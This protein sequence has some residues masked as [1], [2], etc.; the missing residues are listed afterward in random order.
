MHMRHGDSPWAIQH[1]D[2]LLH[3]IERH[4]STVYSRPGPEPE[5]STQN[6]KYPQL[7]KSSES[8]CSRERLKTSSDVSSGSASIC[9]LLIAGGHATIRRLG[10][11]QGTVYDTALVEDM[12][13]GR[14]K[15]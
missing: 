4:V 14:D 11:R 15:A 13:D 2:A 6:L 12:S 5:Q 8:P 3:Y 10:A 1:F 7:D 9:K